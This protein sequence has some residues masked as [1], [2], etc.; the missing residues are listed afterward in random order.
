MNNY[1]NNSNYVGFDISD[2][3]ISIA[4][5]KLSSFKNITLIKGDI[6]S[7]N[8]KY[9][10]AF[11]SLVLARI[12]G[13]DNKIEFISEIASKL[14]KVSKIIYIDYFIDETHSKLQ[15]KIWIKNAKNNGVSQEFIDN[16]ISFGENELHFNTVT[17][18]ISN[19]KK[20]GFIDPIL[21]ASANM[22]RCYML[23]KKDS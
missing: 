3:M 17:E 16:A 13:N 20:A 4:K 22:Y 18:A 19:F 15:E 7:V 10:A 6:K 23:T 21:C 11:L 9:D 14:N 8:D 5:N 1:C 2:E 12:K